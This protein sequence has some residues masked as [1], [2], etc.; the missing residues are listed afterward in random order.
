MEDPKVKL[1]KSVSTAELERRW[2]ALREKMQ[3]RKIDYLV[4]QNSEE[5]MGGPFAGL[6]ISPRAISSP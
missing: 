3:E 6:P 1:T 2:K 5:Y 4:V